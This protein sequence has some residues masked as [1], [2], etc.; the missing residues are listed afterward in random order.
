MPEPTIEVIEQDKK[1][2]EGVWAGPQAQFSIIDTFTNGTYAVWPAD[3]AKTRAT[4][5]T[6]RGRGILD[7][8]SDNLLPYKPKL[9]RDEGDKIPEA[10]EQEQRDDVEVASEALWA[11]VSKG[12]IEIPAK[13]A[14]RYMAKY[15]Y[16]VLETRFSLAK[17]P[18]PPEKSDPLYEQKK[19]EYENGKEF[20]PFSLYAPHP[21]TVLLPPDERVPSLGVKRV[22]MYRSAIKKMVDEAREQDADNL[23]HVC[24]DYDAHGQDF[25]LENVTVHYTP[26]YTS[27][28]CQGQMLLQEENWHGFLPFAHAFGGFG[29][30]EANQDGMNPEKKAQG[31]LWPVRDLIVQYDQIRSAQMEIWAKTAFGPLVTA[32]NAEVLAERLQAAQAIVGDTDVRTMGFLPSPQLPQFMADL[33]DRIDSEIV[34]MTIPRPSYGQREVGVDTVGQHALMVSLARN[35]FIETMEQMSFMVSQIVSMWYRMLMAWG[36]PITVG[37]HRLSPAM[38]NKS[39]HITVLFPQSDWAVRMQQTQQDSALVDGKKLSRKRM[40]ENMGIDDTSGEEDQIDL[41]TVM[42]DP[43]LVSAKAEKI[44][45]QAGVRQM[46]E[47]QLQRLA[48]QG[49]GAVGG[50]QPTGNGFTPPVTEAQGELRGALSNE[51]LRPAPSGPGTGQKGP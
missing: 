24:D 13:Q 50:E 2:L 30:M 22:R 39:D 18:V 25:A 48:E 28:V 7:H 38:L 34:E 31:I 40:W 49:G 9:V 17:M 3:V 36:E 6:N 32:G 35:R 10:G 45:R 14:G 20:N 41:E 21:Y 1:Q 4:F 15:N 23:V 29:D 33:L 19:R 44:R 11:S 27:W 16:S 12:E 46:Y 37:G 51:T 43:I 47:E 26:E 5:R 42:A 8:V